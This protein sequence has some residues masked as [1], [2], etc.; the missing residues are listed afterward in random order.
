M[1]NRIE[2]DYKTGNGECVIC[3]G[4]FF[5]KK[6]NGIMKSHTLC[7]DCSMSYFKQTGF[8]KPNV[9]LENWIK[10]RQGAISDGV[11]S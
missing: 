6:A 9:P 7:L 11:E 10:L 8:G 3:G 1:E 4:S 2:L 5:E